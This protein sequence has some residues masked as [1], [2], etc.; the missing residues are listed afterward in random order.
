[1]W[2]FFIIINIANWF[3]YVDLWDNLTNLYYNISLAE[4]TNAMKW[5]SIISDYIY[6]SIRICIIFFFFVLGT[7]FHIIIK[8]HKHDFQNYGFGVWLKIIKI[9]YQNGIFQVYN[10]Q[11]TKTRSTL[12]RNQY[13]GREGEIAKNF[14][15]VGKIGNAF[16]LYYVHSNEMKHNK[17]CFQNN[18]ISSLN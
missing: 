11:N 9:T 6:Y 2:N 18:V 14:N 17:Q 7:F 1:M 12:K 13:Q 3:S 15:V 8:L 10:K 5:S 4:E 16:I